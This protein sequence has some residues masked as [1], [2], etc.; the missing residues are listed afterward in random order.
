MPLT[1]APPSEKP[2]ETF[3]AIPTQGLP[4]GD[5]GAAPSPAF[6]GNLGEPLPVLREEPR[7]SST[8]AAAEPSQGSEFAIDRVEPPRVV[9]ELPRAPAILATPVQHVVTAQQMP[10]TLPPPPVAEAPLQEPIA[11]VY[12]DE[13]P[14]IDPFRTQWYFKGEYLLWW[15]QSDRVP[16]LVT[17]GSPTNPFPGALGNPDTRILFGNSELERGPQSGF[18]LTAG[19]WLDPDTDEALE[20]SGF[21][22][23]PSSAHFTANSAQFPVLARPF[24]NEI[25]GQQ[26]SELAAF[27]GATLASTVAV[28]APTELWGIEG[29]LR[30]NACCCCDCRIDLLCGLR[31]LNLNDKL[32]ISEQISFGPAAPAP[33][34][35]AHVTVNDSFHTRNEFFGG[36]VGVDATYCHGPWDVDVRSKLALG[37]TRQSVVIDGLEQIIG[38]DGRLQTFV[39]GLLALPSNMGRRVHDRFT[40]IPELDLEVGYQFARQWRAFVGYNFLYWTNV[41]RAGQQIDPLLDPSQ[42]P[43]FGVVVGPRNHPEV[44]FTQSGFWAQGITVGLEFKY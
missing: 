40:V 24:V 21:W 27:P 44:P 32:T 29:N 19:V 2:T 43:N 38:P 37:N 30:C 18:R 28:R 35:S 11:E 34:T 33:F 22:L 17:T 6:L 5:S 39:G 3:A 16:A 14:W 20:M 4:A 15:T 9:R 10:S 1:T 12:P 42:I 25:T 23:A 31:Y 13:E 7:V 26:N 36:Q 41:L 8:S